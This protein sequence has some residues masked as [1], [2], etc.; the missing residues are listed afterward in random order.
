[1]S[2]IG[3]TR[4]WTMIRWRTAD[5]NYR[6]RGVYDRVATRSMWLTYEIDLTAPKK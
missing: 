4:G 6:A 1:M 3:R 2:A 5:N